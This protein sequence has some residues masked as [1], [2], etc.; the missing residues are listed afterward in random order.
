MTSEWVKQ[1]PEQA[2]DWING[3]DVSETRDR[4][5]E[6][7][8]FRTSAQDV[9]SALAMAN[10]IENAYR[11]DRALEEVM[12]QWLKQDAEAAQTAIEQSTSLSELAKWRLLERSSR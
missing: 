10:S 7:F 11:R 12:G 5:A 3:I 2:A 4:I 6:T 8:V 9:A 1:E